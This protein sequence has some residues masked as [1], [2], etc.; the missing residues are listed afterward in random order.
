[1]TIIC[2]FRGYLEYRNV[3]IYIYYLNYDNNCLNFYCKH[4][5]KGVLWNI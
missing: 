4:I 1:M 2:F 5:Q 3:Y